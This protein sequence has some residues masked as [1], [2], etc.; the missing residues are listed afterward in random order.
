MLKR[1]EIALGFFAATAFW[2]IVFV[3]TSNASM[4]YQICESNQYTGKESCSSHNV[5]YVVIW[6]IGHWFDV[7]SAVITALATVAIASFTLTLKR[8]TDRLWIAGE[9]QLRHAQREASDARS[10]SWREERQ[11]REQI[12]ILQQSATATRNLAVNAR[13]TARRELRAYVLVSGAKVHYVDE[14]LRR[15]VEITIKNFGRTPA[16]NLRFWAGAG[17]RE[18]PLVSP[19][20]QPPD[21]LRISSDVLPPGRAS[22]MIV[23]I[24]RVHMDMESAL[25][26]G[27]SATAAIFIFGQITYLDAFNQERITDFRLMCWGEGFGSGKASPCEEGNGYT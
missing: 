21:G 5:V 25:Q 27:T 11:T 13:D 15:R 16:H 23:P 2:C 20:D 24:R 26:G 19:L 18:F 17:V 22:E 6:Y 14:P 10:R 1:H 4:H 8:A 12:D 7:S 9:R 3:L